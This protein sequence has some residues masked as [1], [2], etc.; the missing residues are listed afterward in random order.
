MRDNW[1]PLCA[2][3]YITLTLADFVIFPILWSILQ[4][5]GE[6]QVTSQ[7]TPISLQGGAFIHISFG[8]FL[9]IYA[10]TRS[11]E[12]LATTFQSKKDNE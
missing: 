7:W 12:K 8:A 6:G 3:T 11:K 9:G 5:V 10:H 4:L 2:F 1:R